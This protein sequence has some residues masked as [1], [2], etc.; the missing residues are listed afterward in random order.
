MNSSRR[1]LN[2]STLFRCFLWPPF[3]IYLA[4]HGIKKF[5][6]ELSCDEMFFWI[7]KE[8]MPELSSG[9]TRIGSR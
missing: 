8:Y 5:A 9:S 1:V 4:T 3:W 6:R 7:R 2:R